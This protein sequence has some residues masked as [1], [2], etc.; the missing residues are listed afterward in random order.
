MNSVKLYS[1]GSGVITKGFR[2]GKEPL[3][4][5]IPVKKEDLDDV[6]SSINVLGDVTIPELSY[7]PTNSNPTT[8]SIDAKNVLKELATRLRGAEAEI[9]QANGQ[10]SKG[11]VYGIQTYQQETNGSVFE[12]FRIL[13]GT[14]QGVRQF[15]E[16]DVTSLKFTDPFVQGEIDKALDASFSAIKP[17]SRN[18]NLTIAGKEGDAT[19]VA[20]ATPCAAWKT[21]YQLRLLKGVASLEAQA[22]VD[23]DTDDDWKDVTLSVITG[24]PISFST[25]IADIR[26]PSRSR[27][28]VVSD[29]ATGAVSAEDAIYAGAAPIPSRIVN[30]PGGG[31]HAQPLAKRSVMLAS[32]SATRG[33]GA[34]ASAEYADDAESVQQFAAGSA[35]FESLEVAAAPPAEVKESGD[36][37]VY[38]SPNP[39]TILARKSGIVNLFTTPLDGAKTVLLYKPNKNERRPY[40]AIKFKNTTPNSL[41]KGVCEVYV[42]GDRQGKCVLENTKQGD[43]SFLVHA[44]ET[45]VKAFREVSN[46]ESRRI[47]VKITDSVA[48]CEQLSS[49]ET[50]YRVQNSKGESFQFEIEHARQWNGS[51]LE[52]TVDAGQQTTVDTPVG[53]RISTT[54]PPNS[55]GAN[56]GTLVVTVKET[57]VQQQQYAINPYWLQQNVIII[58]HPL[59]RNKSIQKVIEL[60]QAVDEITNKIN[61]ADEEVTT[62]TE[63]QERLINLIPNLHSAQANNS[64]NDLAEAEGRIKVLKKTTLPQLRKDEKKAKEEVAAALSKLKTDWTADDAPKNGNGQEPDKA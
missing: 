56:N 20:Y 2:L 24:E 9:T 59:S 34:P 12:K 39:V 8:L 40:T 27:V 54:L 53:C 61:E 41:N 55:G 38:T 22:V 18:V 31:G 6:V 64:K 26:R 44:V 1:N 21:R 10:T 33:V 11:R 43:E 47:R 45:G 16:N 49:Q 63:E 32:M 60:Q 25:D 17:D 30:A 35:G 7:T 46:V 3:K 19:A 14:A 36:F 13:L 48:Y 58:N 5:T 29:S 4:I 51:K 37:S 15:E 42:E 57:L 62:L 52:V 28:N 50:R 23:N